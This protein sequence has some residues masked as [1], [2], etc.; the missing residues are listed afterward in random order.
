MSLNLELLA[1]ATAEAHLEACED[2]L[3]NSEQGVPTTQ[4]DPAI[5]PYDGCPACVVREVLH[6]AWPFL[7]EIARDEVKSDG[8]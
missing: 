2:Y 5:A 8:R 7:L 3:F 6:S 4:V 1:Q